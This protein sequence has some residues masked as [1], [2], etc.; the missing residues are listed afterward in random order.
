[1]ALTR[2]QLRQAINQ[3]QSGAEID[4]EI[5]LALGF[6]PY[7]LNGVT[8]GYTTPW[9][10][11]LL[12]GNFCIDPQATLKLITQNLRAQYEGMAPKQILLDILK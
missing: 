7:I 12:V 10:E 4:R 8:A 5:V 1:M 6:T 11:V 2:Q 9:G 3:G